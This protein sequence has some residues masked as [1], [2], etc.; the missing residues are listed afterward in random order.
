M[1]KK[2]LLTAVLLLTATSGA[3]AQEVYEKKDKFAGNTL[4]FTKL[5]DAKLEG[6]SFFSGRYANFNFQALSPVPALVRNPFYL[7]VDTQT[8]GWIFISA[9]ESLQL[10]IDGGEII[11]LKG[12]GSLDNRQVLTADILRESANWEIPLPLIQRIASAKTVEF[13]ILGDRQI[14]TGAFKDGLLADARGFAE[15]VPGLLVVTAPKPEQAE[16]MAAATGAACPIPAGTGGPDGPPRLGV[17]YGPVT[18]EVASLLHMGEPRGVIVTSVVDGS[19][20]AAIGLK[21]GDVLLSAGDKPLSAMCDLPLALATVR[22]GSA[23]PLHVW[24]QGT[25][26]VLQAQF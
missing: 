16:A 25:E 14:I 15:K 9:G 12:T 18:K 19:V 13:R 26:S 7:H 5:R 21:R 11:A 3:W 20:A 10:K 8:N 22:K 24:R 23:L 6:G 2:T 17:M 4:Y 1:K